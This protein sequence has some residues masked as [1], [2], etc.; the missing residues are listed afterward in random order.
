MEL[1]QVHWSQPANRYCIR[2]IE[3]FPLFGAHAEGLKTIAKTSSLEHT[4]FY[5]GLFLDYYCT[6]G[7]KSYMNGIPLVID[8]VHDCAA[9]PGSSNVP[10]SFC[11]TR[12]IAK[13]VNLSL[14]L[15]KWENESWIMGEKVT[16]NEMLALV[17]AAKGLSSHPN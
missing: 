12:D 7:I 17:E 11:H 2:H 10:V 13:I 1:C 6:P 8:A 5:N 3:A 16:W 14:D 15:P 4:V 9:L